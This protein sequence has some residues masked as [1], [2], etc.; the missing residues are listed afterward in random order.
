MRNEGDVP[1]QLPV[2][3]TTHSVSRLPILSYCIL[4]YTPVIM[5]LL[6]LIAG[7]KT[8]IMKKQARALLKTGLSQINDSKKWAFKG[9]N[10]H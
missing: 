1:H 9:N 3:A 5:C 2:T 4:C 6:H 7:V 10:L 8:I